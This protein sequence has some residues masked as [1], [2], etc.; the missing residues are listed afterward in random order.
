MKLRLFL[1]LFLACT[2]LAGKAMA[3]GCST[4]PLQFPPD[5]GNDK[6]VPDNTCVASLDSH[7]NQSGR[8]RWNNNNTSHILQLFDTDDGGGSLWCAPEDG[9]P[10]FCARADVLCL[11]QDGNAVM[12]ASTPGHPAA[13]HGSGNGSQPVWSS[14]T[15]GDCNFIFQTC[16]NEDI[17]ELFVQDDLS[18]NGVHIG[19]AAVIY[20][21]TQ[22]GSD[23][24]R[25]LLWHSSSSD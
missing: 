22:A 23:E 24:S 10:S 11:Q 6:T 3:Q 7:G 12:Y 1:L 20:N 16:T 9:S 21:D 15:N 18:V 2:L 13:C 4:Q 8:L 5:D 14:N 25:Q 17:E 19:E